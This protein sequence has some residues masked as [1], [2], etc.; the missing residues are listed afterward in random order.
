[1]AVPAQSK[2]ALPLAR[3]EEVWLRMLLQVARCRDHPTQPK[4]SERVF[5]EADNDP[6]DLEM[7]LWCGRATETAVDAQLIGFWPRMAC[8]HRRNC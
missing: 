3:E 5:S 8:P 7:A 6:V 4:T 1:M 2:Q